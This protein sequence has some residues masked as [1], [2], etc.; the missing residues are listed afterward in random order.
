MKLS[1]RAEKE[2]GLTLVEVV[3]VIM[4][5]AVLACMLVPASTPNRARAI[6]I[7]CVN[8]LKQVGLADRNWAGNHGDRYPNE[9]SVTNGGTMEFMNGSNGFRFFQI[10][11]NE[12][13]TPRILICPGDTKRVQASTFN[14]KPLSGETPFT[15]NSNLSYFIGLDAK[16][17]DPQ[18]VLM[19]DRNITNGTP[20]KNGILEL[21]ANHP[22]MWTSE[23]HNK[24]GNILLADGSVQQERTLDATS[25]QTNAP[26]ITNR[27]LMPVLGQ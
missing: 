10:M 16:G 19:G 15:S 13:Q 17:T 23:M 1:L 22:A 20:L 7:Q 12:L 11:S 25:A 18:A 26:A 27:L 2:R 3:V 8:N 6:R 24:V 9:I 21:T 14:L 5:I 4:V